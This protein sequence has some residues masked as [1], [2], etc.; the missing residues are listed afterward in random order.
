[1][2]CVVNSV[3]G[4]VVK[5]FSKFLLKSVGVVVHV[6]VLVEDFVYAIFDLLFSGVVYVIVST[7]IIFT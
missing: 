1:M 7:F 3:V 4:V 5:V 2:L 6:V